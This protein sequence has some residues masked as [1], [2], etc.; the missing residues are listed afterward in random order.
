MIRQNKHIKGIFIGETEYKI[1]QYADDTEITLEGD[2]NSFD[3]T[4]KTI[5]TF[6]KASGLFLNAGKINAIWLGNKRN[7]PVKYMPHLR[8]EWNPPKFKIL[9]I[10]FTKDLKECEVLN[11]SDKF[12]EIRALYKVWLKRQMTL[13]GR[14]AVLKSLILSKIIHLWM[15]LSNPP[16]NLVNELQKTV[17]QFVWNRKQDR[18]SRKIAVRSIA[19]GGLGIPNIKTYINAVKLIWIGKLK[20]SENKWKSIIKSTYPNEVNKFW[21]HIFMAYKEFGKQIHVDNSEE[22]V[23]EP[24]FC[25]Q[26]ILVGNIIIIIF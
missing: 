16:D 7:S 19:K 11:F 22:L 6:G 20:T 5:Y 21:S 24:I 17:F 18:I 9:G 1:S 26:N 23:A 3:E 15:L 13:L 10:W 25:N 2:K 8:M 14:V 4:V 12:S